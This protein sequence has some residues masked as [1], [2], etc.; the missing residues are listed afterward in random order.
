MNLPRVFSICCG[1][2]VLACAG[3]LLG[4]ADDS[5]LPV[6][7]PECSLFGSQGEKFAPAAARPGLTLSQRTSQVRGLMPSGAGSGGRTFAR[8]HAAGTIDYFIQADFQANGI[9]P[10]PATTDWEFIRRVTLDL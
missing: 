3:L 9:T 10:A 5:Q 7:H 2:G 6:A 1:I 4:R 8:A